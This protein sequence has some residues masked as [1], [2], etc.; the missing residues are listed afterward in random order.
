MDIALELDAFADRQACRAP[1]P[2]QHLGGMSPG[3]DD[4]PLSCSV[5]CEQ[6][7]RVGRR[8]GHQQ[9]GGPRGE[10]LGILLHLGAGVQGDDR[11]H[12]F[13]TGID[14]VRVLD[15]RALA[16]D[17]EVRTGIQP[18]VDVQGDGAIG[19]DVLDAFVVRVVSEGFAL[20]RAGH[21]H[22]LVE[23]TPDIVAPATGNDVAVVVVAVAGVG[24][25]TAAVG[26][27]GATADGR[28]R[29]RAIGR[30]AVV[31]DIALEGDVAHLVVLHGL[32]GLPY[33]RGRDQAIQRVVL[34][35]LAEGIE[36]IGTALQ[37]AG[38]VEQVGLVLHIVLAGVIARPERGQLPGLGV[39]T[40]VDHNAIAEGGLEDAPGRIAAVAAGTIA[41][42][43]VGAHAIRAFHLGQETQ[44]VVLVLVGVAR[45]IGNRLDAA[46]GVVAGA[47]DIVQ[48][49]HLGGGLDAPAQ[50]V[51]AV[52]STV[53]I[54]RYRLGQPALAVGRRVV[55]P[56]AVEVGGLAP[57]HSPQY[58]VAEPGE[59]AL[60]IRLA[61]QTTQTVVLVA[62]ASL[63]G[64]AIG[65]LVAGEV[66]GVA[67]YLAGRIRDTQHS[68]Q[69]IV[70]VGGRRLAAGAKGLG[71]PHRLA[72]NAGFLDPF[73][74]QLV[75]IGGLQ[76]LVGHCRDRALR[77]GGPGH[78]PVDIVG[79]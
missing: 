40:A 16:P 43:P 64:I 41:K 42:L 38:I 2:G 74:S 6:P 35:A 14:M 18:R 26:R 17:L 75:G 57:D 8:R 66:V 21:A 59:L 46:K 55:D 22:R 23:G 3:L 78:P 28:D 32:R 67:P 36:G 1:H 19:S 13:A 5:P 27:E 63:V 65:Q 37:V 76:P 53:A 11:R 58:V 34:E 25:R 71:Y 69:C 45:G 61:D 52:G 79:I 50:G 49:V 12:R 15:R 4:E 70:E 24:R 68:T 20:A 77:L 10:V 60:G 56:L 54:A 7:Q 44:G 30:I 51:V 39:V 31:T 72:L 48:V 29:L 73:L 33:N 9:A 47:E 62:P